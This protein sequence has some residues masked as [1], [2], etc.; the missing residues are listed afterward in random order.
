MISHPPSSRKNPKKHDHSLRCFTCFFVLSNTYFWTPV[1]ILYFST[2]VSLK[3]IFL[4]ESIYYV[5][6]FA[7]EVPSGYFSDYV[8]RKKTLFLS[9]LFFC[10]AYALFFWGAEFPIL[11]LAQVFLAA[12]FAFASGTDTSLHFALLSALQR[13]AEYGKREGFLASWGLISS[14]GSA[15]LGGLLAWLGEYR[16]AYA[17]SFAF[18]FAAMLLLLGIFDPD[19]QNQ[20]DQRAHKPLAQLKLIGSKL[21]APDL[22]YFFVFSVI[23]TALNHIPYEFYQLYIRD[24]IRNLPLPQILPQIADSSSFAPLAT[25]IHLALTMLTAAFFARKTM[26]IGKKFGIKATF[27]IAF[28]IHIGMMIL[29]NISQSAIVVVLLVL[30]S[31]PGPLTA[32]IVRKETAPKIPTELRATYFSMQSLIGRLAFAFLLLL[33]HIVPGD[34]FSSSLHIGIAFGAA[35]F[36]LFLFL[37]GPSC[38]K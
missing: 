2:V 25:G 34:G 11:A 13:E 22:R 33:F 26:T 10:I 20:R 4:L 14:A 24:F 12:G 3:E 9:C 19:S 27:L 35:A 21:K 30:R 38:K 15:I 23:I 6:V 28:A 29:L 7:L 5:S 1:F 16:L 18:A 31:V 37:P 17:L 32:P 8:G 36:L